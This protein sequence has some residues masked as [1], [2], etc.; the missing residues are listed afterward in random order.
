[1]AVPE[2]AAV[3]WLPLI[4]GQQVDFPVGQ[5]QALGQE[6]GEIADDVLPDLGVL[7]AKSR[8]CIQR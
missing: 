5:D 2:L 1:M 3:L 7:L 4:R 8:I 6:D